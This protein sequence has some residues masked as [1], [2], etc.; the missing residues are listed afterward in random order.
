MLKKKRLLDVKGDLFATGATFA[1]SA[2]VKFANSLILT[3]ILLPSAYGTVA[4]LMSI[5]YILVM[6]SDIGFT[7]CIVRS[8]NGDQ[9]RYF[10]TAWTLRFVRAILDAVI[11]Y[12]CAPFVADLY[13]AP[14][15]TLPLRVLAVWFLID[16]LE[17]PSF[18]LAIRAKNSRLFI[19][20]ESAGNTIGSIFAVIYCYYSRDY[21]GL[22]YSNLVSRG[23][24]VALSYWF[25]PELRPR[26]HWDW[27]S[28]K[29]ISQYTRYVMPSSVLSIFLNQF[30][31][32]V[33]LRLFDLR[34]LGVYS[35]AGNIAS[36]IESL[37]SK[38]SHMV[39]YPRCAHNFRTD[40]QSFT[41][42]YYLENAKLFTAILA[43][44]AAIGG[45]AN[46]LV[47]TL[48]D[49]RYSSAGTVLEA[50]MAR[51]V[52]LALATPAEDMLI[53]T[54]ESRLVLVGNVY[55]AVW[56]FGASM[57]GYYLFGFMG[58]TYGVAL[59]GFPALGYYFWLQKRKGMLIAKYE[60]VKIT[61]SCGIAICAY[62]ASDALWAA[63]RAVGL[64]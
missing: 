4:I 5:V 55:R 57:A 39:L 24:V 12:F 17:S 13:A 2:V 38:A 25:N 19:Y 51:A 6:L 44:P 34:L 20:S 8:P 60:L 31:K 27:E 18:P 40:P 48:Y 35:L 43:I 33:F 45:A 41:V 16:G 3:R 9:P 21:W 46:F 11:M 28:A 63:L 22:V 32:A 37:I 62:L 61:F 56:M 23:V 52:L 30:D 59:S 15:L 49:P 53:A 26:F 29:E 10:N 36:P 1:W 64:R 47:G 42:K 50:F 14:V 7:V 58:F 54:G